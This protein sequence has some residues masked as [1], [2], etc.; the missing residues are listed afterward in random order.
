MTLRRTL[1][2]SQ[3]PLFLA[4]ALAAGAALYAGIR[5]GVA[6][7]RILAENFRSFDAAHRMIETLNGVDQS[8]ASA[9]VEGEAVDGLDARDAL[10]D[11][12]REL[13]LQQGNI[14]EEGEAEATQA[15]ARAWR[16]YADAI[17]AG[18]PASDYEAHRARSEALR[19]RVG[20]ILVLNRTA[21]RE[22]SSRAERESRTLA[23]VL[24]TATLA[25]SLLAIAASGLLLR[26]SLLPL[27]TLAR[28]V[29]RMSNGDFDARI[30]VR[31]A[32]EVSSLATSF[33]TM[34]EHI[35][36]YRRS[37]LGELVAANERLTSV[38]NGLADAVVVYELDG[39]VRTH[40]GL[41]EALLGAD[42]L[43]LGTASEPLHAE[44]RRVFDEVRQ[45]GEM[46]EPTSLSAALQVPG[47]MPRFVLVVGVPSREGQG[48]LSGVT[49]VLRDVT[50]SHR[51]EGFRS[52]LVAAAAH[53]LR[54]P[55][56]SLHMAVHLC[57]EGAA[58]TLS[59][60]QTDLLMAARAD[61]GRL[62]SVV[63]ELLELAKLESGVTRL[64][65]GPRNVAELLAAAVG[66][67]EGHARR[68]GI[69][70]R[71]EPGDRLLKVSCDAERLS[72]VLDNL[73][74]NALIHAGD[75]H[76]VRVRFEQRGD[77]V[78]VEVD[79]SGPG[80]PEEERTRVF[81]KFVR[82]AGRESPGS[83]LGLSIVHDVIHAHG[84]AVGI[85]DSPLGGAR[86]WFRLPR[87]QRTTQASDSLS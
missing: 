26:Q 43:S 18:L 70:L 44:V 37:S 72:L 33:N 66:R 53:E 82:A 69:T 41:A 3:L 87:A 49:I 54:T 73:L 61:C 46:H 19:S 80:V 67:H 86:F 9:I 84:G 15:L 40:N 56:T 14:T 21:M 58:G 36:G 8:L 6:P 11:F 64:D 1:V 59:D 16:A 78:L 48:G 12:E 17:R 23:L 74:E 55:L 27:R 24:V 29:E 75:G 71:L 63:D 83:G 4:L 85:G 28:A 10:R 39:S 81:G 25:A 50:R 77:D 47:T 22:K 65:L 51:L 52:D 57:L 13:S 38:M 35:A 2:L 30:R 60:K 45:T 76:E 7:D 20:E 34:A 79:D 31:G 68:L 5:F 62:Q 42:G 32:D